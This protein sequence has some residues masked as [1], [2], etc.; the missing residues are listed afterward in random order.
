MRVYIYGFDGNMGQRYRA[1][2]KYLGHEAVG[3]DLSGKPG[4]FFHTT[5]DAFIV[6]TPTDTHCDILYKLKDC[7]RPIL[8]EKPITKSL[9]ELEDLIS[10]LRKSGTTLE[11]V[12]QYDHI[13]FPGFGTTYYNYFKHGSDGIYWDC[14]NIIKH[15]KSELLL[16][17][18]SPIWK[19]SVNGYDL[20]PT[21]MDYAYVCMIDKWLKSPRIKNFDQLYAT[22]KKV[23]D[24]IGSQNV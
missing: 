6:A 24:L 9:T 11:M 19:C 16:K 7:G 21:L 15:A 2:L 10:A 3:E 8:C 18:E 20:N 13:V 4:E 5:A 14:I 22:H 12:D 1:I 17:D 23:H